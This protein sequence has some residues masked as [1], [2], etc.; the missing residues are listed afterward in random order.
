MG[1][2]AAP[3]AFGITV[4]QASLAV[5]SMAAAFLSAEEQRK[6]SEEAAKQEAQFARREDRLNRKRLVE[7]RSDERKKIAK[8]YQDRNARRLVL[9][10]YRQGDKKLANRYAINAAESFGKLKLRYG[11]DL[12][13]LDLRIETGLA[14]I[15]EPTDRNESLL[16][17]F[18]GGATGFTAGAELFPEKKPK[19]PYYLEKPT[20]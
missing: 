16:A 4:G 18:E 8:E 10:S 12:A 3:L 17:A 20:V 19:I 2:M 13:A 5:G 11:S 15:P 9:E 6:Q 14:G 7:Q 1:W